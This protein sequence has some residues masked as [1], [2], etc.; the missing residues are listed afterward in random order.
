MNN[1]GKNIEIKQKMICTNNWH[2]KFGGPT[3]E[4]VDKQNIIFI[5]RTINLYL[6]FIFYIKTLLTYKNIINFLNNSIKSNLIIITKHYYTA[7]LIYPILTTQN[8]KFIIKNN[9]WTYLWIYV[10]IILTWNDHKWHLVNRRYQD[11]L[12]KTYKWVF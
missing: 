11:I 4:T 10:L 12:F 6:Y 9:L 5:H 3:S 1:Q 2:T 8:S 7:T